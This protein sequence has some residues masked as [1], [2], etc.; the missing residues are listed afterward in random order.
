MSLWLLPPWRWDCPKVFLCT[1]A[2]SAAT[3]LSD[4]RF[5]PDSAASLLMDL[6]LG[7][8][9]SLGVREVSSS[10]PGAISPSGGMFN[11]AW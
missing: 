9:K 6:A 5:S 3:S 2:G 4:S 11:N 10:Q 7:R 1:S 8:S